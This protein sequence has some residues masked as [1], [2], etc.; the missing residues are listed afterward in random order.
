MELKDFIYKTRT[1]KNMTQGQLARKTGLLRSHI[2]SIEAGRYKR[3]S[4][5]TIAK[6]AYGLDITSEE[7][8]KALSSDRNKK[9]PRQL[10]GP[11]G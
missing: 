10:C 9:I 5:D 1:N 7:V 11:P 3:T 4:P 2:S 8:Y 6:L